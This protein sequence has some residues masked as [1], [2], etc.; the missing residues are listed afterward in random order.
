MGLGLLS[1]SFFFDN[2]SCFLVNFLVGF[3][4][5]DPIG[6]RVCLVVLVGAAFLARTK[7]K[8]SAA[9]SAA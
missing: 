1:S 2:F 6:I 7:R 4:T 9:D 3:L 8:A 5:K